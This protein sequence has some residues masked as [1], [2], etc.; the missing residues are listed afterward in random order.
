M[1]P[2]S[3][4]KLWI[5]ATMRKMLLSKLVFREIRVKKVEAV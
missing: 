2:V 3:I 1:R 5:L 4:K